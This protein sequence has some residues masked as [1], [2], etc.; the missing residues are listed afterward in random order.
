MVRKSDAI[1]SRRRSRLNHDTE[2]G[3]RGEKVRIMFADRF[4]IGCYL[5]IE[6]L[7]NC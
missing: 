4:G 5:N 6:R 7:K 2:D 1:N 3:T